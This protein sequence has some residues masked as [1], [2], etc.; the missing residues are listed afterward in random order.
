MP[1]GNP[2]NSARVAALLILPPLAACGADRGT[3]TTADAG[4]AADATDVSDV[5]SVGPTADAPSDAYEASDAAS[6]DAAVP[7]RIE[8]WIYP[9]P[10][11]CNAAAEY[12]D[13]RHIDVLK[14]QYYSVAAGG[15]LTQ[16]TVAADGCNGFSTAN[17][18]DVKAHSTK[19]LVTVSGGGAPLDALATSASNRAAAVS[20]LTTFVAQVGFSGVDIDFEGMSSAATYAGYLSFLSELGTA[21]HQQNLTLEICAP[22]IAN[23]TD[24]GEIPFR[25]EDIAPLPVDAVEVMAYDYM[26]GDSPNGAGD[27]IAP[28]AWVSDVVAWTFAKMGDPSRVV[29]GV[30]SYGYHG[31]TGAFTV[32]DTTYAE[33]SALAGFATATPLVGSFE[34]SWAS[35]GT[36]YVYVSAS[37]L[38]Q[39][40]ALIASKGAVAVSVWFL[41]GNPWFTTP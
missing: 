41:G 39:E 14:P 15:T 9:G 33:T 18:A 24:Q 17:A 12:S 10:P 37:G 31:V 7:M 20:V 2:C 13:G 4:V 26:I 19:Q 25:Y 3:S 27:P 6:V 36:S 38:D 5:G 29:V 32:T 23:A 34:M 8:A 11:A 1:R 28:N 35:S 21:L 30:P 16:Q 22:P 40:R